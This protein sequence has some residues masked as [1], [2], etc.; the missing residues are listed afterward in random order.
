MQKFR[1]I[2]IPLLTP[3][4]FFNVIMQTIHGFRQ[5]TQAFIISG[6]TG[7]PLDTT[8]LYALY[9]YQQAFTSFKMGYASALAWGMLFVIALLT[10]VNFWLSK[11]WVFYETK[12]S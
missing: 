11:Y 2:T 5:F 1:R 6:G 3:I 12:E 8:L 10:L 4:I 9:L 7:R